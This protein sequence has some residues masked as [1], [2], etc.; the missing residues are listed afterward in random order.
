MSANSKTYI[1][2]EM[3]EYFLGKLKTAYGSNLTTYSGNDFTV[4]KASIADYAGNDPDTIQNTYVSN[5][6]LATTLEGYV[7][8]STQV[9]GNALTGDISASTLRTSLNVIELEGVKIKGRNANESYA[10]GSKVIELD[11]DEYAKL[12]DIS[13]V[14][15]FQGVID[16]TSDLPAA[17]DANKGDV[18]I[19]RYQGTTGTDPLNAEYISTGS[20]WEQFGTTTVLSGYATENWVTS[21]FVGKTDYNTDQEAVQSQIAA[22]ALRAS[23]AESALDGRLDVL[24]GNDTV[25]GSVAKSIKDAIGALDYGITGATAQQ[26]AGDFVTGVTQTDGKIAVFR[27]SYSTMAAGGSTPATATDVKTYVN[28]AIEDVKTTI[29]GLDYTSADF[30]AGYYVTG[31]TQTDGQIAITREV[32][33]S[34]ASGVTALVDG[35]TVHSAIDAVT[36][37]DEDNAAIQKMVPIAPETIDGWFTAS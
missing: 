10:S 12:T 22:E 18:Y 32:K 23:N 15:D 16:H 30:P 9:A 27:A 21:N 25:P 5:T 31:V 24:E 11:L 37:Y 34:V 19:V 33:G 7:T 13:K 28:G 35:G 20:A 14:M 4:Q 6:S 8:T 2:S 1:D 3:L 36:V 26:P 29:S 17:S